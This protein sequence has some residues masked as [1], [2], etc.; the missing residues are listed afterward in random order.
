MIIGSGLTV[1]SSMTL[2]N[3][4]DLVSSFLS[5][6][7]RIGLEKALTLSWNGIGLSGVASRPAR[8]FSPDELREPNIISLE[9]SSFREV[10]GIALLGRTLSGLAVLPPYSFCQALSKVVVLS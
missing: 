4:I 3:T 5:S 8:S 7:S 1:V 6:A 10:L 9:S 2:S